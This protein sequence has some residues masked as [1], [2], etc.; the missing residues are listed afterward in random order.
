MGTDWE[1]V[2]QLFHQALGCTSEERAEFIA[3]VRRQ[4]P[5]LLDEL[6]SLLDTHDEND[7]FLETPVMRVSLSPH[8]GGWQRRIV[9]A[10]TTQA[11]PAAS[12]RD[13][14][15]GQLLD[16]KYRLDELIGRGGMGAVYRATHVGTGHQAAV[17]VMAPE[18]AGHGEFLERFRQEARTIGRLRHPNIVNVTDFGITETDGQAAAYL[19]MEY[20]EGSTLAARLKDRR[21]LP[22]AEALAILDQTC[23]AI[24]EAHRL[25]ILHRDLKPENIWL[26]LA[27]D[28]HI[29]VKV[30]DFGIAYL[31]DCRPPE[32]QDPPPSF[33]A[34]AGAR[35]PFSVTE[36]ETLRLNLTA[37][38]LTRHGTVMGTPRYMS[39]EQCRGDEIDRASDIYTLGVIVYQMLAG[40]TPF[41]GTPSELLR[42]HREVAPAPLRAKRRGVPAAVEAVVRQALSKDPAGRPATAGAFA[43]LLRL[44]AEGYAWTRRQAEAIIRQHRRKLME[45]AVRLQWRGWL[46]AGLLLSAALAL[47]GM[48]TVISLVVF[49]LLWLLVAALAVIGQNALT[50]AC[51]LLVERTRGAAADGLAPIVSAVRQQRHALARAAINQGPDSLL[52]VPALVEG[53]ST[54]GEARRRAAEL[55]APVRRAAIYPYARR[56]LALA[57]TLTAWQTILLLWGNILDG[58]TR[59][60]FEEVIFWLPVTAAIGLAAFGLSLKSSVEQAALYLGA[61]QAGG[62]IPVAHPQ[63]REAGPAGRWAAWKTLIPA[64]ALTALVIGLQLFKFAIIPNAVAGGSVYTVKALNASGVPVPLWSRKS[65]ATAIMRSPGMTKYLLE[66]GA[67]VNASVLLAGGLQPPGFRGIMTTPLM[68]A[69]TVGAT[70]TARL[71]IA[72]GADLHARDSLGRTPLAVA[73]FHQPPAIELLLASGAE[74]DEGTRFGPALLAAARYQWFYPEYGRREEP[75]RERDN[76]VRILIEKGADP[77]TRDDAGRNGL[78]VL[79]ME[80]RRAKAMLMTA[81]ALLNAGCEIN[82]ADSNGRTPLMYAVKYTQPAV[83]DFLLDRGADAGARDAAGMTAPDL[84]IQSGNPEIA[85]LF[86]GPRAEPLSE[87]GTLRPRRVAIVGRASRTTP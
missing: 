46:L 50:A 20:L 8:F 83:V 48:P 28:G 54:F 73:I 51:A 67:G 37:P 14:M 66:K 38:Q 18:L 71:L 19:V 80:M 86:I 45:M 75:L 3:R 69:L 55:I 87:I 27:A 39:P 85:N 16:G 40:E 41:T 13:L 21:P 10:L 5:A 65:W 59:Y 43:F 42:Q 74:V 25:G 63:E 12:P 70:K 82:A 29:R 36:A 49:G 52:L 35:Q 72:H 78:M 22:L 61:L 4:H 58:G 60:W 9:E 53:S 44:Q 32:G 84:A 56:L 7:R 23:A 6:Q 34:S 26:E 33:A 62:E 57:L 64:G 77:N 1:Q 76:A 24:D 15:V 30:L 81:E 68:A 17:K 11:G 2:N 31:H 47:P 79:S